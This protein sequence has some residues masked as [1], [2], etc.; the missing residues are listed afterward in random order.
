MANGRERKSTP[1]SLMGEFS[2]S[3][4][5]FEQQSPTSS[6][7]MRSEKQPLKSSPKYQ[8]FVINHSIVFDFRATPILDPIV[9]PCCAVRVDFTLS[10][11]WTQSL[12]INGVEAKNDAA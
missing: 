1:F 5:S 10:K 6:T 3:I 12:R 11:L 7:F 8:V 2:Y 9:P 4:G